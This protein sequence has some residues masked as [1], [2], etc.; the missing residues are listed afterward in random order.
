MSTCVRDDNE[1]DRTMRSQELGLP[2]TLA[3]G[4]DVFLGSHT[5]Y[6]KTISAV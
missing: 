2:S 3:C 6:G 5:E 1:L 4:E